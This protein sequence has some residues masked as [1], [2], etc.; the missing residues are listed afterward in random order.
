MQKP[1][2]EQGASEKVTSEIKDNEEIRYDELY[3]QVCGEPT[4]HAEID[5]WDGKKWSCEICGSVYGESP[6]E[7]F[8]REAKFRRTYRK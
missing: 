7:R 2:L 1:I 8:G 5:T 6:E 4:S 3:C